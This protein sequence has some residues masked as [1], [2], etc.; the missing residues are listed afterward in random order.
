MSDTRKKRIKALT[1]LPKLYS[2]KK[3][4]VELDRDFSIVDFDVWE[5]EDEIMYSSSI[6]KVAEEQR[7]W[8]RQNMLEDAEVHRRQ[9]PEEYE[10]YLKEIQQMIGPVCYSRDGN[11]AV[12]TTSEDNLFRT[13]IVSDLSPLYE[14]HDDIQY[15]RDF[16]I[17]WSNH[18]AFVIP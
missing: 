11:V 1:K 18:P 2:F 17:D 6:K 3:I 12:F 10:D 9:A 16:D 5:K 4:L 14:G 7:E 8:F 15:A 13:Y